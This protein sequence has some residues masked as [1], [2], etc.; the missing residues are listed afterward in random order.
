MIIGKLLDFLQ[1]FTTTMAAGFLI[2][3]TAMMMIEVVGRY[4]ASYTLGFSN[5]LIILMTAWGVYLLVGSVA[6]RDQHVRIGF[7]IEKVLG[8]RA[9]PVYHTVENV[10]SFSMCGFLIYATYL[11]IASDIRYSNESILMPTKTSSIMYPAW[12]NLVV[13]PLGCFIAMVFYAERIGNQIRS[14]NR[15]LRGHRQGEQGMGSEEEVISGGG[16]ASP[17]LPDIPSQE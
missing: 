11:L 13:V 5:T 3:I 7:F 17:T 6:R 9:E 8:R 4:F 10:F 14:L 16:P 2:L 15:Y 1:R 12:V